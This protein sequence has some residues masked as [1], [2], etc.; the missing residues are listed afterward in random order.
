MPSAVPIRRG[1][2]VQTLRPLLSPA[3][4]TAWLLMI[5]TQALNNIHELVPEMGKV[6]GQAYS[7]GTFARRHFRRSGTWHADTKQICMGICID[8][9]SQPLHYCRQLYKNLTVAVI[10]IE[11][12]VFCALQPSHLRI[13]PFR[14]RRS[15]E[16]RQSSHPLV[17]HRHF[18]MYSV[19]PLP[20]LSSS[21]RIPTNHRLRQ[22]RQRYPVDVQ[23][24]SEL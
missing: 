22:R 23:S 6:F 24:G 13:S 18:G 12:L 9:R 10:E 2:V 4:S 15:I 7:T 16:R 1:Y 11:F 20:S 8:T 14:G 3:L 19:P 21:W 17:S 5:S